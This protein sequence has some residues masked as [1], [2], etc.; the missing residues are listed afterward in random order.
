MCFFFLTSR[1][2]RLQASSLNVESEHVNQVVAT[3]REAGEVT[4]APTISPR[5]AVPVRTCQE[6]GDLN[7][8]DQ[9][10]DIGSPLSCRV[11]L[12]CCFARIVY[13]LISRF[14][15]CSSLHKRQTLVETSQYS[16]CIMDSGSIK[17]HAFCD[18]SLSMP[19]LPRP[20]KKKKTVPSSFK[21]PGTPLCFL[22]LVVMHQKKCYQKFIQSRQSPFALRT[23]TFPK[24]PPYSQ[25]ALDNPQQPLV[26]TS[27]QSFSQTLPFPACSRSRK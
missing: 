1:E 6:P 21:L 19:C 2:G 4:P 14:I 27:R 15:T 16:H 22:L 5:P 20:V 9:P 3:P 23:M 8:F 18:S 13:N 12:C 25:N 24:C 17:V 7:L 10:N 26:L 11:H